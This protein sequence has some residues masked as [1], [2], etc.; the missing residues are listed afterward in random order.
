M[1][2]EK[3]K[4]TKG[5]NNNGQKND[6]GD[7]VP[8]LLRLPNYDYNNHKER[9]NPPYEFTTNNKPAGG[10][11]GYQWI[12][13]EFRASERSRHPEGSGRGTET[14]TIEDAIHFKQSHTSN[15]TKALFSSRG[16]NQDRTTMPSPS[17]VSILH[18]IQVVLF[19]TLP[20]PTPPPLQHAH[21]LPYTLKYT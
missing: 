19:S 17:S 5:G 2:S 15:N 11:T 21:C 20:F 18:V 6:H 8:R 3:E 13:T 9:G 4:K 12:G 1:G 14:N 7:L 10:R 16:K